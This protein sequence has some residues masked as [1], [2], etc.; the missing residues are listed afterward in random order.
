MN[1]ADYRQQ[2]ELEE[3]RLQKT[4]ESLHRVDNGTATHQDVEFLAAELG[5][6]HYI[7]E[8]A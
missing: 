8:V 7:K 6:R 4:L 2:Q 1:E 5:V 3:E